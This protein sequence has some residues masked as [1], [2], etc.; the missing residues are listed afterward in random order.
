[1]PTAVQ[2]G[3]GAGVVPTPTG[4]GRSRGYKAGTVE[5]PA[6]LSVTI[7]YGGSSAPERKP[8]TVTADVDHCGGKVFHD[9]LIVDAATMGLK[10]AVF[11]LEG[12]KKGKE[13]P[14]EP[15]LAN[16]NCSFEPRVQI[17]MKD[18]L[19]KARN[20]DPISHTTHPYYPNGAAFFNFPFQSNGPKQFSGKKI[21][22]E[23]VITVKCDVHSWM[24]AY[25]VVTDNPYAAV[26]DAKGQLTVDGI[27][28]GTYSYVLWH[29]KL[30]EQ[31][32]KVTL[33]A[34]KEATLSLT[35]G[36]AK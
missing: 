3:T 17:A 18:M 25:V 27:P 22:Q 32:G 33:E 11:R 7:K 29:E 36:P 24:Q 20:D 2:T 15:M 12:I 34:N 21:K 16:K 10:N 14:E 35:L 13:A 5:N 8:L 30:G 31:K 26:S 6:T 28:P 19:L 1:V 9:D 23:G 4:G